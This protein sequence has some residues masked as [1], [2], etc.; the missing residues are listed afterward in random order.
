MRVRGS[1]SVSLAAWPN[2][3]GYPPQYLSEQSSSGGRGADFDTGL[4]REATATEG[5]SC[6]ERYGEGLD[7]GAKGKGA[8][9]RGI[10][11]RRV[12]ALGQQVPGLSTEPQTPE[13]ARTRTEGP[14]SEGSNIE[15]GLQCSGSVVSCSGALSANGDDNGP[16]EN[17][18]LMPSDLAAKSCCS[19]AG[20]ENRRSGAV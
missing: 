2:E 5:K 16:S 6:E 11:T 1:L 7:P 19:T 20:C 10:R 18:F 9:I 17:R 13:G 14:A 8:L 12:C 15:S 4:D 3:P